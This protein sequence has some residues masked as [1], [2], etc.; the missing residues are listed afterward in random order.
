MTTLFVFI[1]G[2]LFSAQI[3][4]LNFMRSDK[5]VFSNFQKTFNLC[6]EVN[7]PTSNSQINIFLLFLSLS[8]RK[9]QN[10]PIWPPFMSLVRYCWEKCK[11]KE[12]LSTPFFGP[13]F[14]F[15]P[16]LFWDPNLFEP[17]IFWIKKI[18]RHKNFLSPNLFVTQNYFG[19]KIFGT[20]SSFGQQIVFNPIFFDAKFYSALRIF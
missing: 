4:L 14:F 1:L 19:P 12:N 9:L 18:F 7:W 5:N 10:A 13:R 20:Q 17:E 11:S 8:N 16:K 2:T 15:Q 3:F 6:Q